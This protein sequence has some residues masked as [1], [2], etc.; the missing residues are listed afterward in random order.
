MSDIEIAVCFVL[1]PMSVYYLILS[2][3]L[4]LK[5][6]SIQDSIEKLVTEKKQN[7]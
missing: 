7:D 2:L 4:T 5:L 6:D 1:I 3:S